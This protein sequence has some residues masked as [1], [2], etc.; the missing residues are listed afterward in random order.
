MIKIKVHIHDKA[1][2]KIIP[3][4]CTLDSIV[5][6]QNN[7]FVNIVQPGPADIQS[8]ELPKTESLNLLA[9]IKI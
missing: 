4:I 7:V 1:K 8:F 2:D 6:R 5:V 9:L 3:H